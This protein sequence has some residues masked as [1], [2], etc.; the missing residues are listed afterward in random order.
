LVPLRSG[1][2]RCRNRGTHLVRREQVGREELPRRR[3]LLDG[4]LQWPIQPELE[5]STAFFP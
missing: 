2:V 1:A 5:K 4:N 3:R